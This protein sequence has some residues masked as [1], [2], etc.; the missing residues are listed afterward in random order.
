MD[1]WRIAAELAL[2]FGADFDLES[3]D[4]VQDEIARVA[5]GVPRASTPH[6][7]RRARDGVM[8]PRPST[9]IDPSPLR[10]PVTSASRAPILA[11]AADAETSDG[12]PRTAE[13]L[14]P[15][16]RRRRGRPGRR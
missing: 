12:N 6:L 4:E 8:L 3:V 1:D 14:R 9:R 7:I 16:T 2:R 11:T 13:G 10:I 5:P 15:T